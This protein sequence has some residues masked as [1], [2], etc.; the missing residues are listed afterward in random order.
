[1]QYTFATKFLPVEFEGTL[2]N[3]LFTLKSLKLR[4]KVFYHVFQKIV[5][6]IPGLHFRQL[7]K[8]NESLSEWDAA[9]I[10][11][12]EIKKIYRP[13]GWNNVTFKYDLAIVVLKTPIT[14]NEKVQPIKID[15]GHPDIK[16]FE[17]ISQ[18]I[19]IFLKEI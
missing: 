7:P 4:L 19:S 1:M 18:S 3:S 2:Y 13:K 14:F 11:A 15:S 6:F 10:S 16:A 5:R 17:G 9:N 12:H 8:I